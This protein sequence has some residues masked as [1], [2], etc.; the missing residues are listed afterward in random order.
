MILFGGLALS[1]LIV[2]IE[3]YVRSRKLSKSE[4]ANELK[5]ALSARHVN[6]HRKQQANRQQ[7]AAATVNN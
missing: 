6:D 1:C 4:I 7:N 3:Y 5:C 2:M